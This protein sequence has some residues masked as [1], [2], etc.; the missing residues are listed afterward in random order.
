MFSA[1]Q[2]QTVCGKG[3]HSYPYEAKGYIQNKSETKTIM[4]FCTLYF[5]T[6]LKSIK[7]IVLPF[8]GQYTA[9]IWNNRSEQC[10]TIHYSTL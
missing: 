4:D 8:S 9:A 7:H 6:I 10:V 2:D 1:D 5:Y 3:K